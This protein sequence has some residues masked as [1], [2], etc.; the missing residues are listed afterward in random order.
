LNN[1][2]NISDKKSYNPYKT[3]IK[4]CNWQS[5]LLGILELFKIILKNHN[6]LFGLNLNVCHIV[7]KGKLS[8]VMI[9]DFIVEMVEAI[10]SLLLNLSFVDLF[11]LVLIPI[12]LFA[13]I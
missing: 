8:K 12:G 2:D 7:V 6:F 1:R 5:F 13:N 4:P 3:F 11:F 9:F 10:H